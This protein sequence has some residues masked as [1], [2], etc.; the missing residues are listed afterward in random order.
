MLF[1]ALNNLL[2]NIIEFHSNIGINLSISKLN[3]LN[4][5]SSHIKSYLSEGELNNG[6]KIKDSTCLTLA[7][8]ILVVV[9]KNSTIESLDLFLNNSEVNSILTK[10]GFNKKLEDLT[11]IHPIGYRNTY[12]KRPLLLFS[13]KNTNYVKSYLNCEKEVLNILSDTKNL[14]GIYYWYNNINGKAYVGSAKNLSNRLGAYY[15]PSRLLSLNNLINRAIIKYGHYNFSLVILETLGST[16]NV[17]NDNLLLREQYYIDLYQTMMP[18]GYNM[19]PSDRTLGFNHTESSKALISSI[20]SGQTLSEET[21]L[22]ISSSLK[23]RIMTDTHKLNISKAKQN[24]V[25]VAANIARSKKVWVYDVNNNLVNNT[26]FLSVGQCLDYM[27]ISRKTFYKY[28]DTDL[29]Y[30]GYYYYRTPLR[31]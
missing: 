27:K 8:L 26:P 31:K 22:K 13:I 6:K 12:D 29:N 1:T 16:K 30:S 10:H 5:L 17:S 7:K 15:Y 21:K 11:V 19:R 25:P 23:G 20:R 4:V 3:N 2:L 28:V 9:F 24:Y 14:A 18:K